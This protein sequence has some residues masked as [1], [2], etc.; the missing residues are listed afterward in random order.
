MALTIK[1][2]AA[3]IAL[4][5]ASSASAVLVTDVNNPY[6]Y[7]KNGQSASV[8]HD[9][10][11]NGVPTDFQ[12]NSASLKL[13]FSDGILGDLWHDWA[14]ISGDGLSGVFEVDGSHLF[15]YDFKW[16][17]VGSDGIDSLNASGFLEVTI[18]AL[19]GWKNDF[20]WK[21]SMLKADISPVSV[22]E[23]GTLALLGL[24]MVGLGLT[25]RRRT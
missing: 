4:G 15:G 8:T 1:A 3:A 6:V 25:R 12:V 11:D 20:Y 7:L 10:T 18:T 16:L 5:M 21:T 22:P 2:I 9:L 23:P 13:G 14:E 17:S 24:G 19:E